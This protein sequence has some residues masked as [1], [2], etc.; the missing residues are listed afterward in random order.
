L[1][2]SEKAPVS[3]PQV[4]TRWQLALVNSDYEGIPEKFYSHLVMLIAVPKMVDRNLNG[5]K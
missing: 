5:A 3:T 2:G 4:E 1:N